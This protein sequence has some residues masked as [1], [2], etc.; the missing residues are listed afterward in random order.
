MQ[1]LNFLSFLSSGDIVSKRAAFRGLNLMVWELDLSSPAL[2]LFLLGSP[3]SF[4][5]CDFYRPAVA[6]Q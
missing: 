5:Q 3:T 2:S 6:S 4:L 1:L